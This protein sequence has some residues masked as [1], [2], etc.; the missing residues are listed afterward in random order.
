MK[1]EKRDVGIRIMGAEPDGKV[2]RITVRKE[3]EPGK[4]IVLKMFDSL[5]TRAAADL[6]ASMKTNVFSPWVIEDK[7]KEQVTEDGTAWKPDWFLLW[8][9]SPPPAHAGGGGG[10]GP[11]KSDPVK[12][13]LIERANVRNND[14]IKAAS[15]L[16][17][18]GMRVANTLNVASGVV[19]NAVA[20]CGKGAGLDQ[21]ALLAHQ[22]ADLVLEV[23]RKVEGEAYGR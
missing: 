4:D 3:T 2:W 15:E 7:G 14:T 19:T 5:Y 13:D 18:D 21:V 16:K 20:L 12:N 10:R 11:A 8:K 22:I 9:K 6:E 17:S 1:D 23:Q